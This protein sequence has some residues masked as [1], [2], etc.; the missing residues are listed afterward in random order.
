M[1]QTATLPALQVLQ[2]GNQWVAFDKDKAPINPHTGKYAQ[3][4][5]SYTWK[6]YNDAIEALQKF[7]DT[8]IGIGRVF[9][10]NQGITGI[11]LDKCINAQGNVSDFAQA[12][13]ARLNSYAEYSP[14]G[15]GIH[16]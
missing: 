9:I 11:D 10:K 4:N 6:T 16:I 13:I 15:R 12:V 1:T 3:S 7:P 2:K 8:C 5:K 14:S